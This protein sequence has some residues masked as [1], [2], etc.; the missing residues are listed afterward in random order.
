[1]LTCVLVS[2]HRPYIV[3]LHCRYLHCTNPRSLVQGSPG[4]ACQRRAC[5]R[6]RRYT[7]ASL[8]LLKPNPSQCAANTSP[9]TWRPSGSTRIHASGGAPGRC[10]TCRP[11]MAFR[12]VGQDMLNLKACKAQNLPRMDLCFARRWGAGLLLCLAKRGCATF[13]LIPLWSSVTRPMEPSTSAPKL[14]GGTWGDLGLKLSRLSSPRT[15]STSKWNRLCEL[16]GK[17][18]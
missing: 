7:A 18:L 11:Q 15:F 9:N 3:Q 2:T 14:W 4:A 13:L 10:D 12:S 5:G 1:M 6:S 16:F 17:R 8:A